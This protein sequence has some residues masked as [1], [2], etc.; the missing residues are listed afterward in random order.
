METRKAITKVILPIYTLL[1]YIETHEVINR[2]WYVR[3]TVGPLLILAFLVLTFVGT[4]KMNTSCTILYTEILF[5]GYLR[6]Y[7]KIVQAYPENQTIFFVVPTESLE[8]VKEFLNKHQRLI[9]V[10]L[11][12]VSCVLGRISIYLTGI[13][14]V[15]TSLLITLY[16]RDSG[17]FQ[18]LGVFVGE[19]QGVAEI[20]AHIALFLCLFVLLGYLLK[21]S[22]AIVFSFFGSLSLLIVLQ[23]VLSLKIGME[24]LFDETRPIFVMDTGNPAIMFFLPIFVM[25]LVAQLVT[26]K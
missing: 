17:W 23:N 22:W 11:F 7:E 16:A 4:K 2:K 3:A 19:H 10:L 12:A 20:V 8:P 1:K 25:G 15:L 6:I 21:I 24:A 18:R 5:S 26:S 13:G 14:R 9:L